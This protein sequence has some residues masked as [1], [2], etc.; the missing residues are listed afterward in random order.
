[1]YAV[2]DYKTWRVISDVSELQDGETAMQE[3]PAPTNAQAFDDYCHE[4][5]DGVTSWLSSYVHDEL[6]YDN[7]VSAA[8]YA[9]D[10]NPKFSAEGAAAR[11][12][13]SDCFIALYE[14]MPSYS[15]MPP[16]QWPTLDYITANLP[17]PSAYNWEPSNEP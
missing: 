11:D 1:M 14:A 12:W 9:G 13:R 17:Q 15:A 6:G 4:V 16:N 3:V 8:S 2:T 10:K 5:S 7:I